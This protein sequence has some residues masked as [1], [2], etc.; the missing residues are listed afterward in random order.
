MN[1]NPTE[2]ARVLVQSPTLPLPPPHEAGRTAMERLLGSLGSDEIQVLAERLK[3]DPALLTGPVQSPS[4]TIAKSEPPPHIEPLTRDLIA[5]NDLHQKA[6]P[7]YLYEIERF[8]P[9]LRKK[10]PE[11]VLHILSQ[12][13]RTDPSPSNLALL[14]QAVNRITS[15]GAVDTHL[16]AEITKAIK[17]LHSK[18]DTG[19]GKLDDIFY[20]AYVDANFGGASIF[21]DLSQ[22]WV[23][24]ATSYVGDAMNDSISSLTLSCTS[25]ETGG[26]VILFEN[27]NFV[28]KYLNFGVTVPAGI[29]GYVEEDVSYVG[30]D[31]ND[32]TS[33][34]LIVRR[35]ANE[36]SPVS[37]GALVP[38]SK[39]L[40]IV[41][42]QNQI[43]SAGNTTFTWDRWPTGP[44][45]GSDWH[46]NDP[47]KAFIYLIVP[48][49]VDTQTIFG[50][51]YAQA[52]YW[53]YL[54]V[55][56]QGN[57]QGYVDWYG[58]YVQG[59]WITGQVQD[60]LMQK[61]PGTIGAVNDLVAQALALAN[62]GA[63]YRFVYY[64]PG[65]N[66]ASGSTWDD[67]SVVAVK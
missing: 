55:D 56:G 39:I 48:I 3:T 67:V 61:I 57:L 15:T 43:S 41:N 38:Q 16:K 47:S 65:T 4:A 23:Y 13:V 27:A 60:Q 9:E 20:W 10:K 25:D 34:I 21:A 63:P 49:N 24:W 11:Q 17:V 32:I 59:G 29:N 33:S 26:N 1:G 14:Q 2:K 30:D 8:L 58:C 6:L 46:P 5:K 51:Y 50:T 35:F 42:S 31:F 53:I 22:G 28:G 18:S 40:D 44:T 62:I 66:A 52:R 45:S 64:L 37:I 12:R 36:T 7:S 54:Y 19:S